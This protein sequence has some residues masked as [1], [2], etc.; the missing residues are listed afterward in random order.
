P[1]P[2]QNAHA[3]AFA[4]PDSVFVGDSASYDVPPPLPTVSVTVAVC[5][6]KE[7]LPVT[8]TVTV[9]LSVALVV[10]VNVAPPPG[11][12]EA[13]VTFAVPRS[14]ESAMASGFPDAT[15]VPT[16][17][18]ALLPGVTDWLAGLAASEKSFAA[19]VVGTTA[20]VYWRTFAVFA[21]ACGPRATLPA[22]KC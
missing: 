4:L 16:A 17:N 6:A 3:R 12:T 18:V 7:S 13:G 22:A 15:A 10:T 20:M 1:P 2:E 11:T 8:V 21:E 19:T 9:P 14:G 5:V